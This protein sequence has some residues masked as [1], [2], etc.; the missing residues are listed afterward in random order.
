MIKTISFS[1]SGA[2]TSALRFKECIRRRKVLS[3]SLY[4]RATDLQ[5]MSEYH[6]Y[7]DYLP[8]GH[9]PNIYY[10]IGGSTLKDGYV[11]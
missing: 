6:L 11:L 5:K 10:K 3:P 7:A 2:M 9:D 1:L 4:I 8:N